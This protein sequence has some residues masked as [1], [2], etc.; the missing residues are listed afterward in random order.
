MTPDHQKLP[1][2]GPEREA[3]REKGQFWTPA[4]VAEAMV[5]YAISGGSNHLFDPAVGAGAFFH[6]AKAIARD[7][8]RAIKLIGTEIDPDALQQA[9]ASGLSHDD[10]AD[11]QIT[12]FVLQPPA[13]FFQAIVANPPYI[14][15]HR[16][17]ASVKSGQIG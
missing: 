14:R 2:S 6:A 1:A 3:L 8:G 12:D 5:G 7:T 4:W 10:I 13:D 17:S 15:H 9:Q 16:L 11:V